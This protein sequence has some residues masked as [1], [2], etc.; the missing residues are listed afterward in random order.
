MQRH[1]P[2]RDDDVDR[3]LKKWRD[4]FTA[5]NSAYQILDDMLDD[6]RLHADTGTP[7]DAEVQGGS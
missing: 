2:K 3:W 7:L 6:Y 4:Q 1:E 5:I